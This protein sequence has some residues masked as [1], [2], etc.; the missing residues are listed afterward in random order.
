MEEINQGEYIDIRKIVMKVW[1][2]KKLFVTVLPIVFVLS[3][4]YIV[5]IPRYYKCSVMLAPELENSSLSGGALTSLASSFGFNLNNG[6]TSDAISPVLYPDLIAS[7]DFIISLFPVVVTTDDGELTAT[8]GDY[9]AKH[10]KKSIWSAPFRWVRAFI[11]SLLE[12]DSRY[13]GNGELNAFRLTKKQKDLV[14]V[15]S[16]KVDCSI[17]KKTDVITITVTDQDPLIC[18]LLTDTVSA[19]LQSFITAYRTNKARIDMEYYERLTHEAKAEYENSLLQ[20]GRYADANINLTMESSKLKL[21]ELENEMQ[22]KFNTYTAMSTQLQ[23][24]KAKVQE[25]TPAF[26]VLQCATV[27]VKA[28]GPKRVYF[29]LGMLI[30]AF[31]GTVVYILKDDFIRQLKG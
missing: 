21:T 15:I 28:A 17:D 22:I 4:I 14:D 16:E 19:R 18:A 23:A 7:T 10:Q 1:R 25:R 6:A 24:A 13:A 29:V 2:R 26:T 30:L 8:Y 11:V 27:P 9:M 20:Y 3:C 31:M 5:V 12:D